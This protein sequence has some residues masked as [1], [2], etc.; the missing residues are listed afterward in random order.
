[1][2]VTPQTLDVFFQACNKLYNEG[3]DVAK[4]HAF[5]IAMKV[6]SG[7]SEERYGWLGQFP[8]LREWVGDRVI[9]GLSAYEYSIK[10][11]SFEST[12]S[13]KRTMLEDDVYGLLAPVFRNMGRTTRIHPDKMVFGLLKK[14]FSTACFDGQNFFDTEHPS[15]GENGEQIT[16]SNVQLA[17]QGST[18]APCWYLLDTTQAVKPI[19][20]QDRVPYS[21]QQLTNDTDA[22]V[23][24]RDEY[25]IGVRARLNVG[26]GFWHMAF[27]SQL[28]LTP[29]NYASA[30][31]SM[32][33]LRG[34]QG[35]FLSVNPSVLVVP[36]ALEADARMILKA[37]SVSS[38]TGAQASGGQVSGGA[39]AVSNIWHESAD[40]IVTPFVG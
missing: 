28:A 11:L 33:I 26:F 30:R 17:P 32:Q 25:L 18:P 23:F 40:L 37:T 38:A 19:I 9:N 7:T 6:P 2:I 20:F 24:L 39:V 29:E 15:F 27:G 13:I 4:T 16:V 34:D 31:A 8:Q 12:V 3:W 14:G 35:D 5:D 21:F 22:R 10:N 1:M 36:P